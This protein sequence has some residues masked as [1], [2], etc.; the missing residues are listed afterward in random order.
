MQEQSVNKKKEKNISNNTD[1]KADTPFQWRRKLKIFLLFSLLLPT[2]S[3]TVTQKKKKK[4]SLQVESKTK[5]KNNKKKKE[6][7][8][9][10]L[11][12]SKAEA[13]ESKKI[14]PSFSQKK[15]RLTMSICHLSF[16]L[17][18]CWYCCWLVG[19]L[20]MNLRM[21]ACTWLVQKKGCI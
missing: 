21:C 2:F 4:R 18:C 3:W 12:L 9:W 13:Q 19:W 11:Q 8:K 6:K 5:W 14:S 10:N 15:R 7:M 1:T 17:C 20:A 16:S